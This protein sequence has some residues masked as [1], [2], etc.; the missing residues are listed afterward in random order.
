MTTQ[1]SEVEVD[2]I[3]VGA[4]SRLVKANLDAAHDYTT[5]KLYLC[6]SCMFDVHDSKFTPTSDPRACG[7]CAL[8]G[9]KEL[10]ADSDN[11][12]I[13]IATWQQESSYHSVETEN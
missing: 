2:K 3:V 7:K 6:P 13:L 10:F 4:R 9:R 1:H 8:D 5:R 11:K 12:W